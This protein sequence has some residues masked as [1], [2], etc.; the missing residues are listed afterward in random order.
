MED[1]KRLNSWNGLA[2][3]AAAASLLLCLSACSMT[4][5]KKGE[6]EKQ[7]NVDIET[8]FGGLKVRTDVDPKDTGLPV[9]AGARRVPDDEHDTSSANV[10]LGIPGFGM[11]VIAA[12]FESDDSSDQVLQFYRKEMK[13][14]GDVTECKGDIDMKG[15]SG[16]QEITCKSGGGAR[17]KVELVVGKGSSHRI[18]SVEPRAKGC[19]FALI[20][21]QMHGKQDTM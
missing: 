13:S 7:K 8:P 19:K 15:D 9:Y 2:A 3:A 4:V 14:Y 1:P 6:G 20:Y 10:T 21:L 5:D 18:V 16:D 11:K 17:D 12:K